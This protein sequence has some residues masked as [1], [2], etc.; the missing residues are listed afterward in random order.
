[1]Y[2][3]MYVCM[4]TTTNV[5]SLCRVC[6]I[7]VA[8]S[9]FRC[10]CLRHF[11]IPDV[12]HS[13]SVCVCVCAKGTTDVS[14]IIYAF[15]ITDVFVSSSVFACVSSCVFFS[16]LDVKLSSSV[17]STSIPDVVSSSVC[18]CVCVCVGG[19]GGGGGGGGV[20]I[21]RDVSASSSVCAL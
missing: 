1:M 2:V 5:T 7:V 16:L 14:I 19:G 18:V 10:Q 3:C 9:A 17:L 12:F 8:L 11:S 21:P 15:S 13:S 4:G 20:S 6:A